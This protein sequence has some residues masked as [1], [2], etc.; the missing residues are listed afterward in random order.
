MRYIDG[1]VGLKGIIGRCIL[2]F[3]FNLWLKL[4]FVMIRKDGAIFNEKKI[5]SGLY[6]RLYPLRIPSKIVFFQRLHRAQARVATKIYKHIKSFVYKY[7]PIQCKHIYNK[8]ITQ[9]QQY[10]S[11][12]TPNFHV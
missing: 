5:K 12:L 10:V 4:L 8:L 2:V 7:T 1:S 9:Q 3:F 11:N 6:F